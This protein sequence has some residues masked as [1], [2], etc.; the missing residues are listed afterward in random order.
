MNKF[1][2]P[3]RIEITAPQLKQ[4]EAGN[5]ATPY[6]FDFVSALPGPVVML[7]ALT[8]GNEY[9]GAI[10]LKEL[11]DLAFRPRRGRL[12]ITFNNVA[13]FDTFNKGQPDD[14]RFVDEDFNRVWSAELLGGSKQSDELNRA[15][16]IRPFIDQADFLLDLHSMHETAPPMF[17][18]GL[19]PKNVAFGKTIGAPEY[20]MCDAGHAQGVRMRDYGQFGDAQRPQQA[21][22]LEAGQHWEQSSARTAR[23]VTARTLLKT[24]IAQVNDIPYLWLQP[25]G[26]NQKTIEVSQA[27]VPVTDT[28]TFAQLFKGFETLPFNELIATEKVPISREHP[29]GIR[30]IRAPYNDCVLVMPSTRHC[31]PGV[32]VVRLGKQLA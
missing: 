8:H 7:C 22:L 3:Y 14:S 17:V 20:L 4:F 26:P 18:C 30:E 13:A 5:C 19:L 12:I 28:F 2:E 23:D 1:S 25:D 29:K 6:V 31:A 11:L 21:V 32:T 16:Q 27:I 9:S 15:R 24:G 10:V